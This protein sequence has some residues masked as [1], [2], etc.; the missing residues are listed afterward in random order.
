MGAIAVFS[1]ETRIGFPCPREIWK[2]DYGM[3]P[4]A[5]IK[6]TERS[7]RNNQKGP[8]EKEKESKKEKKGKERKGNRPFSL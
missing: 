3:F 8:N 2:N 5:K 7:W 1:L 4:E 6:I